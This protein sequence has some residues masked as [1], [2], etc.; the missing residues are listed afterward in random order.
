MYVLEEEKWGP[1]SIE[2]FNYALA[3]CIY[4]V[5]YPAVFWNTNKYWGALF[6]FQLFV[7]G[8]QIL[9]IYTGVCILYKVF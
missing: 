6:S 3:L 5:R 2:F 9:L 1:V 4:A 7:N 8:I